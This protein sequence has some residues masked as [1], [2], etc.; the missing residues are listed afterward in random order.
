[1]SY[2]SICNGVVSVHT[3]I[4]QQGGVIS[5]VSGLVTVGSQEPDVVLDG[6][7]DLVHLAG[8]YLFGHAEREALGRRSRDVGGQ[9]GGTATGT[10]NR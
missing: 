1:L 4:A 10:R 2:L 3:T 6:L 7:D 9:A 8:E 5:L